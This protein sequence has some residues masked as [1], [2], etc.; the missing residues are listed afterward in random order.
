MGTSGNKLF[1]ILLVVG[2]IAVSAIAWLIGG[3]M[4]DIKTTKGRQQ[5]AQTVKT[6]GTDKDR[7]GALTKAKPDDS[8]DRAA[9][10]GQADTYKPDDADLA[11]GLE[12]K[13]DDDK[14]VD[15]ADKQKD[16][17]ADATV[18]ED[19]DKTIKNGDDKTGKKKT[20]DAKKPTPDKKDDAKPSGKLYHVQL[21]RFDSIDNARKLADE[22]RAKTGLPVQVVPE[23]VNGQTM[24]RVQ[25]G[26]Y[27]TREAADKTAREL[28]MGG[29]KV[30][31]K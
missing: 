6:N 2:V 17:K 23:T 1:W 26:A 25:G 8:G 27:S 21:G 3:K 15:E 16:E 22:A 31:V 29:Y 4:Y 10:I 20:D 12:D 18:D 13:P 24:Y 11:K 19:Q 7:A 28:E 14:K 9:G 30:F 5:G